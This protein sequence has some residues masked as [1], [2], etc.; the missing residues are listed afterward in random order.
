MTGLYPPGTGP[1]LE[2]TKKYAPQPPFQIDPEFAEK[3][4][5]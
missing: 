3:I 4:D 1:L 2:H 5:L